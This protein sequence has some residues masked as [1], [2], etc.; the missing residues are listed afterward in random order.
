MPDNDSS[1]TTR[2]CTHVSSLLFSFK[3]HL[4]APVIFNVTQTKVDFHFCL[5]TALQHR[6]ALT[7]DAAALDT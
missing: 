3:N 5:N 4:A 6:K 2:Q 7:L 1:T